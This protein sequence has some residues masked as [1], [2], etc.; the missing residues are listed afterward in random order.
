MYVY[1]PKVAHDNENYGSLNKI[2]KLDLISG[3]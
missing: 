3:L 2:R 1:T